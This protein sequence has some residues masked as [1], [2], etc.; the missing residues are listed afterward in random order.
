MNVSNQTK[1]TRL[2]CLIAFLSQC[3]YSGWMS[4][5]EFIEL[6]DATFILLMYQTGLRVKTVAQL[7]NKHVIMSEKLL[8]VDGGL[9]KNHENIYLPFDDSLARLFTALMNQN[10]N[11]RAECRMTNEKLFITQQDEGINIALTNNF[12]QKRLN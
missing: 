4:L 9:L 3:F 1:L 12:I 10:S 2:K 7:E 11:V 8:K 6:R 5:K